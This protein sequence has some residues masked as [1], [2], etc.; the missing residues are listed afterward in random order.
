MNMN[1]ESLGSEGDP[2]KRRTLWLNLL[3]TTGVRPG[4]RV[5]V[6][7]VRKQLRKDWGMSVLAPVTVVD[8]SER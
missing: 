4:Q 2:P 7:P 8:L 1:M 3:R 6:F 5:H